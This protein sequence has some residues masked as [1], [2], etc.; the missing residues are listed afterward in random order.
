VLPSALADYGVE[1][2]REEAAWATVQAADVLDVS[3]PFKVALDEA[4]VS[5]I[6]QLAPY[7]DRLRR[8]AAVSMLTRPTTAPDWRFG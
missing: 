8:E 6:V 1:R 2:V 7:R 4:H 5:L 3:G